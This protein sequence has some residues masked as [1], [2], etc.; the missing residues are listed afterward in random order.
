MSNL[1]LLKTW[2]N[3]MLNRKKLIWK[4][5]RKLKYIVKKSLPRMILSHRV[6]QTMSLRMPNPLHQ[7]LSMVLKKM[8]LQPLTT[9]PMMILLITVI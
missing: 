2:H 7:N 4:K 9:T 6:P 5:S 3:S 1:Y 8:S